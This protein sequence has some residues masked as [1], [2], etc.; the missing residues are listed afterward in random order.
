MPDAHKAINGFIQFLKHKNIV[1]FGITWPDDLHPVFVDYFNFYQRTGQAS[2]KWHRNLRKILKEFNDFLI[3]NQVSINDLN[4]RIVDSFLEENKSK[5]SLKSN[6]YYR[7]AIRGFLKF[8]YHE[9][10]ISDKDLSSQLVNAPVFNQ[11]NPPKFLRHSE[12][13]KLLEAISLSTAKDLRTNAIVRLA[14]SSGLRPIEISKISLDDIHFKA[15]ELTL[16][17]RKGRNPITFPLPESTIKA[18]VAYM[19]GARPQINERRLFSWKLHQSQ[20]DF[21]A[22]AI[23]PLFQSLFSWKLHQEGS[24]VKP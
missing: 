16:P 14:I 10:G 12:I 24:G 4:I 5:K 3:E 22:H 8:L 6:K 15:G 21:D 9:C 7:S 13:K 19:V 17:V 1:N 11:S 18:I 2:T 23:E 20:S